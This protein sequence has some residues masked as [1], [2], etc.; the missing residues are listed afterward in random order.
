[1][2]SPNADIPERAKVL[3]SWKEIA[4]FLDRAERTVK[5]WERERGLP[6]HRVPGGERSGVFAYS[7]ELSAWLLGEEGRAVEPSSAAGDNQRSEETIALGLADSEAAP[8]SKQAIYPSKL[9]PEP[10][11]GKSDLH[12]LRAIVWVSVLTLVSITAA[13]FAFR[14]HGALLPV[15]VV[16]LAPPGSRHASSPRAEQL[17]LQGRYQ[18][19]LRTAESLAKS[20][21]AYTQAIVEDPAYAQAYAGLAESY[22]LLPQ[23]AQV[24]SADSFQRAKAAASRAIELDPNLAA[25]HRAKAFVLFYGYWDV[26]RQPIARSQPQ[27]GPNRT[28]P[29]LNIPPSTPSQA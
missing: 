5:R 11:R 17:Y 23:Y 15:K 29:Q 2:G 19:S 7:H 24:N 12:P 1:M 27:P 20:V 22:D 10:A 28:R 18:W 25:G 26:I 14:H 6:V 8:E 13:F 3:V 9:A 16:E 21:D 4:S